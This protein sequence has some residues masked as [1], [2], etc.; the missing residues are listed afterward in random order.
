M[1]EAYGSARPVF[2]NCRFVN[3]RARAHAVG[4]LNDYSIATFRVRCLLSACMLSAIRSQNCT[5][6]NNISGKEAGVA[7]VLDQ[8][9]FIC[10]DCTFKNNQARKDGGA[11]CCA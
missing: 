9:E 7:A 3:N 11:C 2:I 4:T 8:S 10:F 1:F 5:F 6:E